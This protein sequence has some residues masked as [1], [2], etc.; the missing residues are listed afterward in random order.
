MV[1]PQ[2][3]AG[4][5]ILFVHGWNMSKFDKDNFSDTAFKRLWHQGY[6]GRFGAFRWPTFFFQDGN[7]GPWGPGTIY[8]SGV[9]YV[10]DP[11]HFDASEHRAWASSLGLLNL[12]NQL[13]S[14]QFN[15][16]VRMMAHSMGNVV[17][18]EALRRAQ[19]GQVVHTYIASQA[20]LSARCYDAT[21]PM[22]AYLANFGPTTPDVYA[23]FWTAGTT[24]S[25]SSWQAE[26]KPSY[27]HSNYMSGKAGRSFNY[28]NDED[29]ALNG[30]HWQLNQQIKPD[31]GYG[32]NDS[33]T[34]LGFY[35]FY[36]GFA[37]L[38]FPND[39]YEIFAW[40]AESRSYALGSQWVA[41][42]VGEANNFNLKTSLGYGNEHKFHS[43]Q[44]R[45][46]NMQRG[47]Y[48]QQLLE[49]CG[50]RTGTP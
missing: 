32:Y 7:G 13:N 28:Y 14:G 33:A 47:Q 37:Q 48:W 6:K 18:G 43:G 38:A 11:R 22:M 23:H 25:P 15:G 41:G 31:S 8:V 50:L 46:I 40:A 39:R 12:L 30:V 24:S 34:N 49:D 4:D 16:K 2:D 1:P 5:Y 44:F 9:G 29:W 20:A 27:M 36:R 42:T 3:E 17:A 26:G 35:E 21:A 19:S 10:P 45:G